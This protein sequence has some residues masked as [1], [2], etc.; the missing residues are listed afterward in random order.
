MAVTSSGEIKLNADVNIEINDSLG[1]D[2]SLSALSVGAG[3]SEPHALTEFYGYVDALAPS[4]TTNSATSVTATSITTNGDV[5]SDGGASITERGFYFGTDGTAAT[6]NTKYTVTGTTGSFNRAFTGLTAS[7]TYYFWAFATNSAGTTIA[8]RVTQAT[9]AAQTFQ[10]A[11]HH[12]EST[13]TNHSATRY[14]LDAN[15]SWIFIATLASAPYPGSSTC[16]NVE[17]SGLQNRLYATNGSGNDYNTACRV[18][19]TTSGGCDGFT[20][21]GSVSGTG[22]QNNDYTDFI[23]MRNHRSG[24]MYWYASP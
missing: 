12:I 4:V 18:Y 9:S 24:N 2:V 16:V 1:T 17:V 15:N 19:K 13:N 3:F 20:L 14:Y 6:S 8:S 21:V 11:R 7:T 10:T 23:Q 5:T 22:G